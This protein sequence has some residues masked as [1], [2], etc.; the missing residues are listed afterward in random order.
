MS[1]SNK[2]TM[3]NKKNTRLSKR[4]QIAA[5]LQAHVEKK[6]AMCIQ[7]KRWMKKKSI[8]RHLIKNCHGTPSTTSQGRDNISGRFLTYSSVLT[9]S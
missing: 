6:E 8:K 5:D 3:H 9:P 7:C 1:Q 4:K 2:S